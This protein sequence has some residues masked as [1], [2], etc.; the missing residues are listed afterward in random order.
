MYLGDRTPPSRPRIYAGPTDGAWFDD[1]SADQTLSADTY[2]DGLG[3][4]ALTL[5]GASSGGGSKYATCPY[6]GGNLTHA[7]PRNFGASWTYR[8]REGANYLSL[9]AQDIVG[10]DS[11]SAATFTRRVDRCAVSRPKTPV[12]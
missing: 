7:C 11:S 3:M 10:N 5:S 2:D 8:L 9:S 4:W 12:F 1:R 6:G